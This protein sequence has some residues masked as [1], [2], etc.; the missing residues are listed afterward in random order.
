MD[1]TELSGLKLYKTLDKIYKQRY[2]I[3]VRRRKD[4]TEMKKTLENE[5]NLEIVMDEVIDLI[6][7][8]SNLILRIKREDKK[9]LLYPFV[10]KFIKEVDITNK[11]IDILPI[12]GMLD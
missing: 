3:C 12:K 2:N 10:Q 9:D 8:N 5:P 11:R 6:N 7:A 4:G 1:L